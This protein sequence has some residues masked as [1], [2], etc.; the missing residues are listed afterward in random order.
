MGH[1][2]VADD[3]GI[4]YFHWK[5]KN[6]YSEC[7]VIIQEKYLTVNI[8]RQQEDINFTLYDEQQ[9]KITEDDFYKIFNKTLSEF[10]IHCFGMFCSYR[11]KDIESKSKENR[12]LLNVI[13]QTKGQDFICDPNL[14]LAKTVE[15]TIK[16]TDKEVIKQAILEL[17]EK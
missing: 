2:I 10:F 15:D 9:N 14:N 16:K 11:Y 8:K 7:I 17:E 1:N 4:T 3:M 5:E 12:V 13:Y 6:S